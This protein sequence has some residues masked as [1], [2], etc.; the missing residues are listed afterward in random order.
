MPCDRVDQRLRLGVLAVFQRLNK[1]LSR[2]R[3]L[4]PILLLHEESGP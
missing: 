4:S 1:L 2:Q 3:L